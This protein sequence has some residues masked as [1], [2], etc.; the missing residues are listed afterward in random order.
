MKGLFYALAIIIS[1]VAI[2]FNLKV[3]EAIEGEQK[4]FGETEVQQKNVYDTLVE[5]EGV[6][7]DTQK[8]L[9]EALSLK[10]D[11]EAKIES[12]QS[13]EKSLN[14]SLAK[15]QVE[16]DRY[17]SKLDEVQELINKVKQSV[18]GDVTIESL[19]D[20][21]RQLAEEKKSKSKQLEEKI[22]VSEKLTKTVASNRSE[23][24]RLNT[25]LSDS[26]ARVSRNASEASITSVSNIWGFVVISG[27]GTKNNIEGSA[28][29][30]VTRNG[31][32]IGKLRI[33][34]I[35]AN[36]VVADIV[37]ES[38]APG[39]TLYPGDTVILEDP[40]VN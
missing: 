23:I 25:S 2:F 6:L 33:S 32:M 1:I 39:V 27:I 38:L 28:P 17:D 11:T 30:L 7:E 12:A 13:K 37:Q 24:T 36:Q 26:R 9:A 5:T 16:I 21:I 14:R 34:A 10:A 31:K 4:R 29:L 3:K 19:P 15:V 8:S 22:I 40:V 20:H 35:E 18:P